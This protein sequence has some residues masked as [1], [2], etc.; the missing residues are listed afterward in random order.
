MLRRPVVTLGALLCASLLSSAAFA[1]PAANPAPT[2]P[3]EGAPP[4]PPP[5]EIQD[6]LLAPVPPAAK[7]L[8]GWREALTLIQSRSVDFAIAQQ[9]VARA[10]GLARQALGAALPQIDAKGTAQ[11]DLIRGAISTPT[12]VTDPATGEILIDPKKPGIPTT[13]TTVTLPA[14]PNVIGTLTILQPVI[15]PRVWYAVGTAR[16]TADANKL[17]LQDKR[18]TLVLAVANAIVAVVTAERVSEV[19]RVG[20]KS[21]LELLELTQRKLRAGT[22]TALDVVRAKQDVAAARATIVAGNE[23]LRQARE[24]LGLALGFSEAYSVPPT[25]SLNE[26]EQAAQST[27]K[28]GSIE[29]RPDVLAAK[30]Q[31]EVG[32][33]GVTDAKLAFSPTLNAVSLMTYSYQPLPSNKHYAWSIQGVLTIPIWDGGSRYGVLRAA[34]ASA[35]EARVTVVGTTRGATLE[36]RQALRSIEVAERARVESEHSRDLAREVARLA[37]VAFE[38]GTGTSFDLVD[39]GRRQRE[40]ELDLAVKEFDVVKAKIAALLATANCEY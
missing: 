10:D 5:I 20:L 16:K 11:V 40:A 4:V 3:Q 26:L 17:L 28:P 22:G 33:R 23:S 32:E 21:S 35:E 2:A 8:S 30:A 24:A 14:T 6:D 25:I 27:C 18:R 38:A 13:T 12:P 15:A 37:R 9:E 1:Q 36:A 31:L 39:S 34:K 19:N 7:V 29:D